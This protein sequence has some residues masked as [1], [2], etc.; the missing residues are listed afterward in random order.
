M[1]KQLSINFENKTKE[2]YSERIR[3]ILLKVYRL[4]WDEERRIKDINKIMQKVASTRL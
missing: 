1:G 2:N 3:E 4:D